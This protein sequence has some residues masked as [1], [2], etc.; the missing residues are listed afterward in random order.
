MT[1][2]RNILAKRKVW[3]DEEKAALIKRYPDERAADLA[4]L[5]GCSIS[6]IY[7]KAK[8]LGLT[9]S[10]TFKSSA[11]SG[12]LDGV[13]GSE[14]RFQ[15]GQ[16]SWN[17][18]KPCPSPAASVKTQFKP[19]QRPHNYVPVGTTVVSTTGYLKTKVEEPNKWKFT[20]QL[21][22]E[23]VHGPIHKGMM[24]IFKNGD[25]MNCDPSNLELITR[26]EHMLR[27]SVQNLPE[28]LKEIVYLTGQVTKTIN[29]RLKDERR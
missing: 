27:H 21:N 1:K 12:R 24:L 10:D 15:K 26:E 23:L 7:G 14:T 25:R 29:R 16:T 6:V 11:A 8:S 9:K 22:W 18:G 19:G 17:K 20:H 3:T 28:E 4:V 2:S 13:R 5:F